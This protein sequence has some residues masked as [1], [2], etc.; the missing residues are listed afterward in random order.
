LAAQHL[1]GRRESGARDILID[2][3]R[4]IWRLWRGG[5]PTGIDRVCLAY[6]EHYAPRAHAVVQYK[7]RY[8][9]L[10]GAH[11]EVLFALFE[12][13]APA[14]RS[15]FLKL[16]AKAFPTARHAPPQPG[17]LY[18]N[19][20][21]TG[22]E[23]ASLPNWI[24]ANQLRAIYF[25]HDLIPLLY[26]EYCRPGEHAKHEKR[27]RNV[28]ASA[29]GLIGNS[30][31]TLDDL[32]DFARNVGLPTSPSIAA[33]IA[34]SKIPSGIAPKTFDRPHFI[35]IGTIEGRKNHSLLL[36]IWKN[37]IRTHRDETPLLVIVGQRGWEANHAIA[38]LD[39]ATDLRGHV[40]ELT[41]CGDTEMAALIAGARALLMP[42]F[43]EGFG[44][45]VAEA[46]ETGTPVI[47]SDL[48]VFREFA[49]DIPTYLDPLDGPAWETA[50][51][52]FTGD[53]TERRRQLQAMQ[54]YKAPGW[55]DHFRSV[56]EWLSQL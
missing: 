18:L 51:M 26:P 50:I 48:P 4:L 47:A 2:V 52:S 38:M 35:V 12:E 49:G 33:W 37:L 29:A 34:G 36:H 56:D 24:A 7:G 46:L 53:A 17:R 19:I 31:A 28:L 9:I 13:G 11:S 39:R 41:R 40:L 20:G 10:S 8:H 21:H 16:G 6:V 30:Q 15:R 43:A 3:S 54:G 1:Q 23:E 27:M 5:L 44:L 25:V 22:L 14:F 55:A 42:S 45:P 32:A